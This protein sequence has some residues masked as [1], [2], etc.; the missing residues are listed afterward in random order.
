MDCAGEPSSLRG[1]GLTFPLPGGAE[2][3]SEGELGDD[4]KNVELGVWG[5]SGFWSQLC[6]WPN[7]CGQITLSP[8]ASFSVSCKR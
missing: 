5:G 7:N 2:I 1:E 3:T 4:E 8:R 6:F